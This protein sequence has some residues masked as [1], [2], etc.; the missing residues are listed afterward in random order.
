M[1]HKAFAGNRWFNNVLTNLLG[2]L[3]FIF[4]GKCTREKMCGFTCNLVFYP[5]RTSENSL[6]RLTIR[7]WICSF[8]FNILSYIPIVPIV[9]SPIWIQPVD[10]YVKH[11]PPLCD[12]WHRCQWLT[13]S[14]DSD[15]S[16]MRLGQLFPKDGYDFFFDNQTKQ[17]RIWVRETK[18]HRDFV[19]FGYINE[20]FVFHTKWVQQI[21]IWIICRNVYWTAKKTHWKRKR[22]T[23]LNIFS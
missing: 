20:C 17:N 10:V 15:T 23:T 8:F 5:I 12:R 14:L 6:L 7:L 9:E 11:H 4:I 19:Y 16:S 21:W 13:V 2:I 1:P 22:M 18:Y 3:A